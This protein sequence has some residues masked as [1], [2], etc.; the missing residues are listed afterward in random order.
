MRPIRRRI[1]SS[2]R[3]VGRLVRFTAGRANQ[4]AYMYI[5]D[6][7][8]LRGFATGG[9]SLETSQ[10]FDDEAAQ[11]ADAPTAEELAREDGLELPVVEAG[12]RSQPVGPGVDFVLTTPELEVAPST[13]ELCSPRKRRNELRSLNVTKA[14]QL[15]RRVQMTHAEVNAEL[16]RRAGIRRVTEATTDQLEGRLR[17]AEA[18]LRK[19][20]CPGGYG[21]PSGRSP[22]LPM[23]PSNRWLSAAGS[24]RPAP[25]PRRA[26][27]A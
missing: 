5:P 22:A 19:L 23:L 16:N 11:A 20:A 17:F 13:V 10:V 21:R 15:A 18:W 14:K 7:P 8:R 25:A 3:A 26:A 1:S 27:V 9:D 12:F 24:L 2:G 6:D 4:R